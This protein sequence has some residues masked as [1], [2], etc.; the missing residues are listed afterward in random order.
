M[1]MHTMMGMIPMVI[2]GDFVNSYVTYDF[3]MEIL[4][5]KKEEILSHYKVL[6]KIAWEWLD[7]KNHCPDRF[8]PYGRIPTDMIVNK[9]I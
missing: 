6:E 8:G 1:N 2:Q 7:N 4:G 3:F 9:I 5:F